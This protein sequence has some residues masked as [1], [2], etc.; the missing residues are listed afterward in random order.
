[1]RWQKCYMLIIRMYLDHDGSTVCHVCRY[2]VC[3]MCA[4]VMRVRA[5][6]VCVMCLLALECVSCSVGPWYDSFSSLDR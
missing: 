3:A 5:M 2:R 6:G 1:M 4:C